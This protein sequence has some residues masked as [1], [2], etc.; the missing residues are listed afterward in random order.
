MDAVFLAGLEL[1]VMHHGLSL[2][3]MARA[4][5]WIRDLRPLSALLRW[6]GDR[7]AP[8]GSDRGGMFVEVLGRSADDRPTRAEWTLLA[9][10]DLG[11][12]VPTLAALALA[13][14]L[15]ADRSSPMGDPALSDI[16]PEFARLGI[17]TVQ[18]VDVWTGAMERA[19]GADLDHAPAAVAASHR[20]G[21]VHRLRGEASIAGASGALTSLVARLFGFPP[22]SDRTEVMVTKRVV[23]PGH[24][25]WTRHMGGSTFRS[26]FRVIGPGEVEERFG[27][28][29]FRLRVAASETGV[30]L[31]PMGWRLGP[32]PLPLFLAPRSDARE[33]SDPAGRL[34][35]DVP[36]ALPLLGRLTHYKGWLAPV[37]ASPGPSLSEHPPHDLEVQP[38]QLL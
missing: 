22:A 6:G 38:R 33:H 8:F 14:R 16:A 20:G 28:F 13:R 2:L 3:S 35:F 37:C 21:P 5:G 23:G 9:E 24:E 36:I 32:L 26:R 12:H 19:L 15:L 34:H 17:T 31:T 27:P 10:Q 25:T 29:D 11:P 4:N 30:A 18:R 1:G 7:L